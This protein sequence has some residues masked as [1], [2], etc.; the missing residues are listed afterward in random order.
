[1]KQ[2]LAKRCLFHGCDEAL[3]Q[4]ASALLQSVQRQSV[5]PSRGV[6]AT[7]IEHVAEHLGGDGRAQ[8]GHEPLN[9]DRAID[10]WQWRRSIQPGP[11]QRGHLQGH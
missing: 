3:A 7:G 10:L 8:D 1:M 5:T 6:T 9:H 4:N 2:T 11:L